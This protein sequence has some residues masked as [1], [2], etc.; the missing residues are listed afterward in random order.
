MSSFE[1]IILESA[2]A[3]PRAARRGRSKPA[4]YCRSIRSWCRRSLGTQTFVSDNRGIRPQ[5][6]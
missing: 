3:G 2:V 1:Y 5:P 4:D 6:K